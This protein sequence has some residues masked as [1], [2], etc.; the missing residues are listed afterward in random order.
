MKRLTTEPRPG[1]KERV[2]SAGMHYHT[3]GGETYWDESV[4]YEFTAEEIDTIED[5]SDELYGMCLRAVDHII[6]EDL[7]GRIGI[8]KENVP[9]IKKSWGI[10]EPSM[11]GRFDLVHDGDGPPKLLEFN[12]DTPTTLLEASVI[13]WFW[14][15]DRFPQMDQFNSIHERMMDFWKRQD[16][17]GD[18]YFCCVKDNEEDLGNVEYIRDV[19]LQ[20]GCGTRHVFIDDIG[21]DQSAGKFVDL[22]RNFIGAIFKLYPWEWMIEEEFGKHLSMRP[23]IV[24]EPAWKLLLSNKGILPVLWQM[25]PDHPNLLPAYFE[26]TFNGSYVKKPLFSREGN[27]IT[28]V[29]EGRVTERKSTYGKEGYVY[30]AYKRIPEFDGCYTTIGSWIIDGKSA[31]IGVRE[32]TSEITSDACRFIPHIFRE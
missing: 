13:Q 12:A 4:Y 15:K 21:W 28:I 22:D 7:F 31:G 19:A 27:G 10:K 23:W 20:A 8:R 11:Y 18:V 17:P 2:E 3:I 24:I 25:Y 5:A 29:K 30:Q 32:D 26:N 9:F 14:M 1:W 16:F 6:R